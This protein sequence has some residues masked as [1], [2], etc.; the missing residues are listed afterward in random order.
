MSTSNIDIIIVHFFFYR[1]LCLWVIFHGWTIL[2]YWDRLLTVN[3]S[4]CHR[5]LCTCVRCAYMDMTNRKFMYSFIK[6]YRKSILCTLVFEYTMYGWHKFWKSVYT[7]FFTMDRFF[8]KWS[9]VS[10]SNNT[11]LSFYFFLIYL[12]QYAQIFLTKHCSIIS[13]FRTIIF[14]C[15][16]Q[17]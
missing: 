7:S 16:S 11:K 13:T 6:L 9:R 15:S 10:Q 4:P 1:D 8:P 3:S 5:Y 12:Y 17:Y 14:N 2:S